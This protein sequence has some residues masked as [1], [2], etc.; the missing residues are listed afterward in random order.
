V[1]TTWEVVRSD[2]SGGGRKVLAHGARGSAAT[3]AWDD[4]DLYVAAGCSAQSITVIPKRGGPPRRLVAPC[5]DGGIPGG[6]Y[7][8]VVA[9]GGFLAYR[10]STDGDLDLLGPNSWHPT[11][12]RLPFD[13][14]ASDGQFFYGE[15]SGDRRDGGRHG[16]WR[17]K[18]DRPEWLERVGHMEDGIGESSGPLVDGGYALATSFPDEPVACTLNLLD[19]QARHAMPIA[20]A[21]ISQLH[22]YALRNGT[23][24]VHYGSSIFRA[25]VRD[26]T[27]Y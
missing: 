2:L 4:D 1:D 19:I 26:L 12:S 8:G 5:D 21:A 24:F 14:V 22:G 16:L 23:V 9:T 27:R 15:Q 11:L 25:S 17:W 7:L 6:G 10:V 3:L 20:V 13:E 18:P